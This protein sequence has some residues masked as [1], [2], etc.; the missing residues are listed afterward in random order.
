MIQI[1]IARE[2]TPS[3]VK[4]LKMSKLNTTERIMVNVSV[5]LKTAG[6]AG[7]SYVSRC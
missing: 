4:K 3:Q 1:A 5:I 2:K 7:P 6:S